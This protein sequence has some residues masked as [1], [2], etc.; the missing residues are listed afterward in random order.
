MAETSFSKQPARRLD[1]LLGDEQ[2]ARQDSERTLEYAH[3]LIE[4]DM[5]N[6]GAIQQRGDGRHQHGVVGAHDLS[7][8]LSFRNPPV[9]SL[10]ASIELLA[11]RML[12]KIGE[13]LDFAPPSRD[14]IEHEPAGH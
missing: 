2:P 7:Q 1:M 10:L 13:Q 11:R 4:N 12:C 6:V 3:V 9:R 8:L 5:G 14:R